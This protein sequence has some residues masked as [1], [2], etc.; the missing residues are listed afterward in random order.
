M[1]ILVASEKDIDELTQVEIKSKI[2]S[3]PECT[4]EYEIVFSSRLYRWQTY[5]TGQSPQTSK[6]ERIVLK[7]VDNN[8]IIGYIA[9][10]L[11]TRYNLD[12]E[13]QSFYVLKK[14]QRKN[15]GTKL[16]TEFLT[17]LTDMDAR[18]LCV[19]IKPENKYK[20][21]YLKYGG[22]FL[23]EHW[24]YWRDTDQL[25]EILSILNDKNSPME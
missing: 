6:P 8:Q 20:A 24:I 17:W 22:Q 14:E 15:I 21:F 7:A 9:G 19:G 4:E 2:D 3:I 10:H 23:N 5:F 12:A 11:T 25:S 13:I 18:S 16:L 1:K